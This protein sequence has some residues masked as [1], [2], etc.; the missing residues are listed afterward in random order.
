MRRESHRRRGLSRAS[1]GG[2]GH[3]AVYVSAAIATA[4]LVTGFAL[5]GFYFGTFDHVFA[6]SSAQGSSNAPYGVVYLGEYATYA[7]L[8]PGLNFTNVTFNR[9]P[10][11][12]LA[13][14]SP[15]MDRTS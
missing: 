7:G 11:P 5:A 10:E 8:I 1:S 3:R 13:T 4:A 2:W 15:R 14:T 9:M 12:V 6:H